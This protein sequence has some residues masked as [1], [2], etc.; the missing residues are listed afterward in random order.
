VKAKEAV[1]PLER[2]NV[3]ANSV[4]DAVYSAMITAMRVQSAT[5]S[6]QTASGEQT[7]TLEIDGN[8]FARLI[9]PKI[10]SEADRQGLQLLMQEGM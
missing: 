5:T 4:G 9:L 6:P 8:T 10:Q 3:I 2:D 1:I 7:I